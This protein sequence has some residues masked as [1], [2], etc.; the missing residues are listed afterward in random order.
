MWSEQRRVLSPRY[1]LIVPDRRGYGDSPAGE[2][3][4]LD[5]EVADILALLGDGAHL[6]GF[7]YGGLLALLAAARRPDLIRSLTVIEPPVFG[8][9][10]GHIAVDRI[11]VALTA[12]YDAVPRLTPEEFRAGFGRMWGGEVLALPKLTPEQRRATTRMMNERNP[13]Q[14]VVPTAQ[15]AET[16]LPK[17]V[18]SGGWAAAFEVLC[19]SLALQIGGER[20]IVPG[21]GH[22]VRHP[23]ITEH[24]ADFLA[25]ASWFPEGGTAL[26]YPG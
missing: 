13:A 14:V 11:A 18:I 2:P 23:A 10:R 24:M 21:A 20:A 1:R 16:R 9:A 19:D 8:V 17:F 22:G 5:V 12:L 7:S 4:D 15:L 26:R 3:D 6:V 25:R